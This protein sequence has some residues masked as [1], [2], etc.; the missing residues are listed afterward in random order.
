MKPQARARQLRPYIEEAAASLPD[1]DALEAVELFPAWAADTDYWQGDRARDP[2]DG[3]LYKLIIETP[4]GHPHHSQSDWPPR[5]VPAVWVR[6]DDPAEE[7]PEW[8]QPQGAH[9]SYS[10]GAKVS[11]NDRH[12]ISDIDS[13]VYEPGVY[14]WTEA[15]T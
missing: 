2:V 8:H 3:L 14:G 6:V 1:E 5:L 7:W 9:D 10:R 13:N 11:H 15:Q 4:E 12:W